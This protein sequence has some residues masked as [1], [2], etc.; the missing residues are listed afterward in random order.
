MRLSLLV[1]GEDVMASTTVVL[2]SVL[3]GYVSL[4]WLLCL[5]YAAT[6]LR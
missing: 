4:F 1:L 5:A 6:Y 3:L 2:T